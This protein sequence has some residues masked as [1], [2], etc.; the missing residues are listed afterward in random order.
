MRRWLVRGKG[1]VGELC[2][3]GLQ[4]TA[5][6]FDRRDNDTDNR[7][8]CSLLIRELESWY[9][10]EIVGNRICEG[11]FFRCATNPNQANLRNAREQRH[12]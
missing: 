6:Q 9:E 12:G 11:N 10:F 8:A 7:T 5:Q 4:T 1:L 3:A 2:P